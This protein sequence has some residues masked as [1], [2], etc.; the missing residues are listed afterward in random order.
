MRNLY[1]F[2]AAKQAHAT[3]E[4]QASLL[5]RRPAPSAITAA[6]A[7]APAARVGALLGRLSWAS[8]SS[9]EPEPE[10]EPEPAAGVA[11]AAASRV[12]NAASKAASGLSK[13]AAAGLEE[14]PPVREAS[15]ETESG[16]ALARP[17]TH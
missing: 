17:D 3:D 12:S 13:V 4:E 14:P 8:V 5:G 10:P 6:A 11:G 9:S 16:W 7:A 1:S 15:K 2:I